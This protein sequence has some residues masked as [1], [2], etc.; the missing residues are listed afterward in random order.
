VHVR[1]ACT[2]KGIAGEQTE[3]KLRNGNRQAQKVAVTVVARG[4]DLQQT[5]PILMDALQS[6]TSC[7]VPPGGL[8]S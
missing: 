8:F 4:I 5:R 3:T 6:A 2:R 1:H 7:V